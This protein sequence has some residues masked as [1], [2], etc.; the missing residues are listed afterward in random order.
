MHILLR[1]VGI[2]YQQYCY[3]KDKELPLKGNRSLKTKKN[4]KVN[5]KTQIKLDIKIFR[6]GFVKQA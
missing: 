1:E 2:L 3:K 6:C 4:N 5:G